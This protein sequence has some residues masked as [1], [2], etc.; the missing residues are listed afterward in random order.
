[1][2]LYHLRQTENRGYDT[3]SDM[4]VCASNEDAAR[5]IH[6][7]SWQE[8]PWKDQYSGWCSCPENVKVQYIGEAAD[9]VLEGIICASFHAG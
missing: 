4:V 6:P 3:Y 8:D 5:L 2:K 7:S 1:M 9:N